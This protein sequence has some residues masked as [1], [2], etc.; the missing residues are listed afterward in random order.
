MT[1]RRFPPLDSIS[2]KYQSKS[3]R[4]NLCRWNHPPVAAL[5]STS[6]C[7]E[8]AGVMAFG[9]TPARPASRDRRSVSKFLVVAKHG[10]ARVQHRRAFVIFFGDQ[11]PRM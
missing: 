6:S 9:R 1:K 11:D 10:R 8:I 3:S 7:F 5:L 4:G 2:A